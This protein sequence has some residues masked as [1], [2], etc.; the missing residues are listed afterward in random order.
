MKVT[1]QIL[2]GQLRPSLDD[3]GRLIAQAPL[4]PNHRAGL[5]VSVLTYF[6]ATTRAAFDCADEPVSAEEVGALITA[7]LTPESREHTEKNH[8]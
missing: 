3:I 5:A 4:S 1:S 6:A 8:G 7:A 2:F